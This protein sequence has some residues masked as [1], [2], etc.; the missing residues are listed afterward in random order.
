MKNRGFTLL[1]VLIAVFIL[2][3]MSMMIWQIT[4]NTYRG[5]NKAEEYDEVY[6][7]G[8]LALKRLTDDFSM[9]FLISQTLQGKSSDGTTAYEPTFVSEDEG[10]SDEVNFTTFA[11]TRYVKNEKKSDQLEVGYSV[12]ECPESEERIQCLMRRESFAIDKET[13]EGGASFPIAKDVKEFNLEY[14]DPEK[15]EWRDDWNS[16]DPVF[17]NKLPRA[18]RITIIFKDPRDENEELTFTTSVM[19]PLSTGAIDF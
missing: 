8:R 14:Y 19:F 7:H 4:N 1:E 11:G 2:A 18:A 5:I 9:A 13:K 6:Q 17:Q 3:M 16:K 12:E 15:Q 10:S